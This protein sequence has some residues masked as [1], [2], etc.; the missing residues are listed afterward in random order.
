MD[1]QKRMLNLLIVAEVVIL[2]AV[3]AA[4]VLVNTGK[5]A[6]KTAESF[7]ESRE[8][9]GNADTN[10]KNA[11]QKSADGDAGAEEKDTNASPEEAEEEN[12][13]AEAAAFSEQVQAKLAQM[14][15][16][17]KVAQMFLVTPEALTGV[18]K[19]EQAG[20]ASKAAYQAC[21]VGGLVYGAGN[22][23]EQ[24]QTV[25]LLQGFQ[26]FSNK[27]VGV[28]LF[29]AVS[30]EGGAE[31]S[32]LASRGFYEEQ[33]SQA[34]L[35]EAGDSAQAKTAAAAVA[36]GIS[37]AGIN[38]NLA[39]VADVSA[40]KDGDYDARTFGSDAGV[41]ADLVKSQVEAYQGA[42]VSCA[43]KYFPG[44]SYAE[45]GSETA[46][47]VNSRTLEE[48][49]GN[50]FKA[51]QAGID[52]GAHVVIV[53]DMAAPSLT[54]DAG[55]PCCLSGEAARLLRE[56]M[57]HKGLLMTDRLDDARV[58]NQY[59]AQG[60]AIEAV[61]AGMDLLYCPAEFAATYQALVD[62]VKAGEVDEALVNNAAG[63][64]LT[65]KMEGQEGA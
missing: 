21:P 64:I 54:G 37:A 51:Y 52:A 26:G 34:S 23:V 42:G 63:R 13:A 50:E 8:E 12:G 27:A 19:V 30:E 47:P 2:V 45:G 43:L 65:V 33:P 57:G 44:Q 10:K 25:Q 35:G 9:S 11:S 17:Q 28:K 14:T 29:A 53:G 24:E 39:P 20:E 3:S 38:M 4:G 36:A 60:A 40:G 49:E 7:S 32:L 16:E 31:G 59:G 5:F 48:M 55:T 22:F 46:L 56:E 58:V 62:A 6:K 18:D 1:L 61:K 41:A 15:L